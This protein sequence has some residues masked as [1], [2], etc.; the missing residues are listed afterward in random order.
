MDHFYEQLI[1]TSKTGIYKTVNGAM[2]VF[3]IV[4]LASFTTNLILVVI[5]LA[6]AVAC[7]FYKQKL[8]VEFEY[9]FT[10]GEIDIEKIIE[11]KK[12]SKVVAFNIKEVGLIA[13]E[14]SDA[15]KDFYNKPNTIVKCYPDTSKKKVYVAMVTE[16]NNKMQ[17]MFVPDEKFLDLC[18]KINPRAVKKE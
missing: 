7:F 15:V 5:L 3:A 6:M 9:Q 8:F 12:R 16:G 1:T 2:Y 13:P 10:N 17:L 18:Y 11:M 14:G 4:G